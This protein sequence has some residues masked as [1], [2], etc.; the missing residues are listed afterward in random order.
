MRA[1]EIE[2]HT[3]DCQIPRQLPSDDKVLWEEQSDNV[4][5]LLDRSVKTYWGSEAPGSLEREVLAVAMI[6][7]TE[8]RGRI[9]PDAGRLLME[10]FTAISCDDM[11]GLHRAT[12]QLFEGCRN[13]VVDETSDY[14]HYRL[15]DTFEEYSSAVSFPDAVAVDM[16]D[17]LFDL[18][19]AG[20]LG[21]VIGGA[22][23]TCLE[24]YTTDNIR[25]AYGPVRRYVRTP[26]TYNDDIT[27]E[28][29]LLV[30]YENHG[31]ATTSKDIA[32]EWMSR[33]GFG[34]SA[35]EMALRNLRCG[36]MPPESG[37]FNNPF[38][39]WIGSQMRGAICG[40]IWPGNPRKA[41]EAAFHD[42]EISHSGNGILGEVFNA[43]LTSMAFYK[44]DMR[45]L[46]RDAIELIPVDSE[47]RSVVDFALEQC[48]SHDNWLDAWRPCEKRLERYNWVH[49]YPNAAIEV[50]ALW[51]GGDDFTHV[52]E[53]CGGCG[54][55]VDCVAA[56]VM[57][58]WCTAHEKDD[59]PEY[60]SE[61]IGDRLDTYMWGMKTLS[62]CQ[63]A[64]R[65]CAVAR[66]LA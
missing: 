18:I 48:E 37:R 26:N 61:P 25:K 33:I 12:H 23:G 64:E 47:Y 56:Q 43:V 7:A 66:A 3:R 46:L 39:E 40:Q 42:G 38:C 58:V 53:I 2:R 31:A 41:A 52:L 59:I 54:Q 10:G 36:I 14:W 50:I 60:W 9:V 11:V 1:W 44:G 32:Y 29:A 22:Y 4:D 62:L 16:G 24:G 63:I 57:T 19:Y 5:K 13:A 15:Y 20:W 21:Q 55:D 6:Q 35:E 27:Y 28:L 51:F 34:W 45:G 30:A 8:N 17:G 65:T 49:A